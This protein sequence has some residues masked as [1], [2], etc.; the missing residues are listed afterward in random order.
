MTSFVYIS[1]NDDPNEDIG[2]ETTRDH[3]YCNFILER[4]II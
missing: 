3:I 1:C 4:N 2:E